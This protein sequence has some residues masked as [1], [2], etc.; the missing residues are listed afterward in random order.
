M[1]STQ[2]VGSADGPPKS[3]R[4]GAR[5]GAGRKKLAHASPTALSE[6]DIKALLAEPPP[7]EIETVAQKHAWAALKSLI[8]VLIHGTSD[9]AR[10]SAAKAVLDRGY[11]KPAVDIGGTD[12][13]S[14]FGKAP[15][16]PVGAE[17]RAEAR[18]YAPL[19][20]EVL[21]KV[22]TAGTS[23]GARVTA[24]KSLHDRGLGTVATAKMPDDAFRRPLGKK[25]Q[26]SEAARAAATEIYATPPPPRVLADSDAVQ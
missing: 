1:P 8:A 19:A 5:P 18:K 3:K 26:A 14:L 7:A 13:I 9:P 25:E 23:E 11:G 16:K 4:G 24:A 12:Q 2:S 21:N 15:E 17:I 10:V 6:L 20:I 22:A